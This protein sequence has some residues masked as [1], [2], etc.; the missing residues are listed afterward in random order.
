MQS[1]TE[2]FKHR[3]QEDSTKQGDLR[4]G[5]TDASNF[6]LQT[7]LS[8]VFGGKL[9]LLSAFVGKPLW[10]EMGWVSKGG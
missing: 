8:M 10:L 6:E 1:I 3:Q 2:T 5:S 4:K 9:S 7:N